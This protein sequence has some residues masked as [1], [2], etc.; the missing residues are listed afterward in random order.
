MSGTR[1]TYAA[2][3]AGWSTRLWQAGVVAG[4][5]YGVFLVVVALG[6]PAGSALTGAFPGQ[7]AVKAVTALLLA[8]AA[9]TRVALRERRLLVGALMFSAVG[10]FLLAMPWWEPSFVGGLGAFLVAHLCFLAALLPLAVPTRPRLVASALVVVAC[11]ALLTWFWPA[12]QV[13]GLTIPVVLYIAVLAAMVCAALLAGLP[14]VWTAVGAVLFAVSDAMIGVSEFVRGD[15]LLAVPIWW[16][17]AAALVLITAGLLF[18][19]QQA[20]TSAP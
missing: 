18:G 16:C 2:T 12:L 14:T 20:D 7:P 19:R 15:Q 4:A 5:G 9:A 10:D 8:A 11:A 1:T 6:L 13:Q 3:H 17:Y